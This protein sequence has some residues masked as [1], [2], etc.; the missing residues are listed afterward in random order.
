M[1]LDYTAP[2]AEALVPGGILF[3]SGTRSTNGDFTAIASPGLGQQ[4]VIVGMNIQ[5]EAPTANTIILKAG[6]SIFWR[7]LGQ[8]Q[9]DGIAFLTPP[10]RGWRI[11]GDANNNGN[12]LQ[13]NLSASTQIGYSFAYF[14][15]QI[16][17]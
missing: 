4:L 9:G 1:P 8:N 13:I 11:G 17:N 3:A 10:G 5:N 14:I 15:T 16:G 12:A 2:I 6:A 7:L